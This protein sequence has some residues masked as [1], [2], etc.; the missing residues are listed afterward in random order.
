MQTDL[1]VL[2]L[3]ILEKWKH[4]PVA[5]NNPKRHLASLSNLSAKL[6]QTLQVDSVQAQEDAQRGLNLPE[7]IL[8]KTE[9]AIFQ[10]LRA[11][12]F[13]ITQETLQLPANQNT[14]AQTARSK[15]KEIRSANESKSTPDSIQAAR[16]MIGSL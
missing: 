14:L 13:S 2:G 4:N 10:F 5:E 15:T 12:S 3:N 16:Q 9:Q 6:A 7:I 1:L 8:E 11:E